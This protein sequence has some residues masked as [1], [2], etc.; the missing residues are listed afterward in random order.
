MAKVQVKRPGPVLTGQRCPCVRVGQGF[1]R[2]SSLLH[3]YPGWLTLYRSSFLSLNLCQVV[4]LYKHMMPRTCTETPNRNGM[5][6][7]SLSRTPILL[8]QS[9]L[10]S[11]L[12][13]PAPVSNTL[14]HHPIP[15][16]SSIRHPHTTSVL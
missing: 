4:L 3:Q 10:A 13:F 7:H 11:S 8:V 9:T 16:T 1:V 2:R 14:S 6:P 12:R 15:A 5:R